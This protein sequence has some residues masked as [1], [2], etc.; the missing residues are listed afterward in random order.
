MKVSGTEFLRI[1]SDFSCSA[2]GSRHLCWVLVIYAGMGWIRTKEVS[3]VLQS[4]S[5]SQ[6]TAPRIDVDRA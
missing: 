2:G 6:C 5:Q 4:I 1:F 3:V